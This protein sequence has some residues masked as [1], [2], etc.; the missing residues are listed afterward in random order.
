MASVLEASIIDLSIMQGMSAIFLIIMVFIMIY[1]L[2]QKTKVLGGNSALDATI[3]IAVSFMMIISGTVMEI[4]SNMTPILVLCLFLVMFFLMATRFLGIEESSIVA[5]L[6]GQNAAW[7]LIIAGILIFLGAA[8]QVV[9]PL[10]AGGGGEGTAD[11]IQPGET[12]DVGTGD[13]QQDL[14]NTLFH[15]T[16]LGMIVLLLIGSFT[17]RHMVTR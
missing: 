11:S 14:R 4:I 10:L 17:I 3:A 1:A 2:L 9:G 12:G 5:M 16:F 15:P 8:G 6:G 7:W 13:Y